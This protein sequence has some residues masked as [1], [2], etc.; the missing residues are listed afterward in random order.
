MRNGRGIMAGAVATRDSAG[1]AG[2]YL[3]APAFITTASADARCAK[4]RFRCSWRI[5]LVTMSFERQPTFQTELIA[6]QPLAS[7]DFERLFT[8]ASDPLIWEQHPDRDRYKRA[9]FDRYFQTA[10][11][12][13]GAFLILDQK[14]GRVVGSSR[15]YDHDEAQQSIAIGYTFLTRECW[16]RGFNRALKTLMLNHA[17]RFV[18]HVQFFVGINNIRSRTAMLK[19]GGRL[20]GETAVSYTGEPSHANVIYQ[21]DKEDWIHRGDH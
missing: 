9:V 20:I 11:E 1:R 6:V 10:M 16:G 18:E 19:L 21:I 5:M 4:A 2:M 8:A 13:G 14:S 7:E 12:S 3:N 17:F 15:Y